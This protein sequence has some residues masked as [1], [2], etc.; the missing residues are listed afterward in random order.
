MDDIGF[1]TLLLI[2]ILAIILCSG[3]GC[4]TPEQAQMREAG[5]YTGSAGHAPSSEYDCVVTGGMGSCDVLRLRPDAHVVCYVTPRGIS[6][7]PE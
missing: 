5:Y 4:E 2:I 6:C 1:N 3:M 7:L